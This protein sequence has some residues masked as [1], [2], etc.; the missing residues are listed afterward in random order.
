MY[1]E[2]PNHKINT[3]S[4]LIEIQLKIGL[5]HSPNNHSG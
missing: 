3:Q 2:F 5:F 4:H 1:I